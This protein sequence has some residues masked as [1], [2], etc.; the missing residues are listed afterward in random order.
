[1]ERVITTERLI[2]RPLALSDAEALFQ[3]YRDP[4]AMRFWHTLPHTAVQETTEDLEFMLGVP[5]NCWWAICLP[6]ARSKAKRP[7]PLKL[8]AIGYIGYLG[9]TSIPGMGYL[10][11]RPH[12]RKGY[13]GEVMEPVLDYGFTQLGL[14]RVELWIHRDNQASQ[15]LGRRAGFSYKGAFPRKYPADDFVS[16]TLVY[17]LRANEWLAR[18]ARPATYPTSTKVYELHPVLAV[19]D[20]DATLAY[21]RDVLGF[22]VNFSSGEPGEASTFG[23]VSWREWTT[24]GANIDFRLADE[25]NPAVFGGSLYITIGDEID[26]VFERIRARGATVDMDLVDQDYGRREFAILDCNGYR[27]IFSTAN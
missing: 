19:R 1:M 17:G 8:P 22:T 26:A 6:D 20:V 5:D 12:W 23:N 11:G 24:T 25:D 13:A 10:L 15:Q 27:L 7:N 16:E 2:L 18:H 14:D 3:I 9:S 4:E 21:Y